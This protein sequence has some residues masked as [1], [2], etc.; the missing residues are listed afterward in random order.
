MAAS[1]LVSV[2]I[3][4]YNQAKYLK[5]AIESVVSQE[6]DHWECIV[7]NDGSNDNTEDV[8]RE[9]CLKDSRIKLINHT[10]R[11][12]PATRNVGIKNASGAY[13]QFLDA[14]DMITPEK[15]LSQTNTF[16][17]NP[18]IDIVYSDYLAFDDDNPKKFY[19]YFDKYQIKEPYLD[20]FIYNFQTKFVITPHAWLF[21][22][23][24]FSNKIMFDE[25][26]KN[27]ED[28]DFY[29]SIFLSKPKV[30]YVK[31]D[32]ALYRRHEN[33]ICTNTEVLNSYRL[34]FLKKHLKNIDLP[35]HLR[36]HIRFLYYE[37]F[38]NRAYNQINE[39]KYLQAVGNIVRSI[40]LSKKPFHYLR[41]AL[42]IIRNRA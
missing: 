42:Y 4:C 21:K 20:D 22:K 18:E 24:C 32:F 29:I 39:K 35:Q 5:F 25:E 40:L 28:F 7:I 3:P 26:L 6:Y 10:N 13:I 2:I 30:A 12:L 41:N 33:T 37:Y 23:T 15:F 1:P 38:A 17:N 34:K 19:R 14:D 31:G 9:Y 16:I 8:A 27:Y 36:K 11:G